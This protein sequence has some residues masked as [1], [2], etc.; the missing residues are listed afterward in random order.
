MN[1]ISESK[2][3]K[4]VTKSR[5][6]KNRFRSFISRKKYDDDAADRRTALVTMV[7]SDWAQPKKYKKDT[8]NRMVLD[9]PDLRGSI[10]S[11]CNAAIGDYSIKTADKTDDENSKENIALIKKYEEWLGNPISNFNRTLRQIFYSL[12]MRDVVFLELSPAKKPG[13]VPW[14]YVINPTHI[15]AKYNA[16]RTQITHFE[17]KHPD[18]KDTDGNIKVLKLSTDKIVYTTMDSL[19][20][21]NDPCPLLESLIGDANLVAA[22]QAYA[23]NLFTAG[24]LGRMAFILKDPAKDE[25]EALKIDIENRRGSSMAIRGDVK[26]DK[27]SMSLS[28]LE[29]D[30]VIQRFVEKIM[31]LLSTPPIIMSKPDSTFKDTGKQEMNAFASKIR[32]KQR[33]INNVI[34]QGMIRL[35]GDEAKKLRFVLDQWVDPVTQ[36]QIFEIMTR[37]GAKVVNEIRAELNLPPVDWGKEPYNFNFPPQRERLEKEKMKQEGAKAEGKQEGDTGNDAKADN[38]QKSIRIAE[39]DLMN[40]IDKWMKQ[41]KAL[42]RIMNGRKTADGEEE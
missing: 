13:E 27:L 34:D 42:E 39:E 9:F 30:K 21:D 36:A 40:M 19:D 29:Y 25:F 26:I 8:Y 17:Y 4:A 11:S 37:I 38:L 35:K 18:V 1:E 28:D 14:M 24:G 32:A 5:N 41:D 20:G 12:E 7:G 16:L 3:N 6:L 2:I 33:T 10:T 23:R 31:T 15:E 22:A